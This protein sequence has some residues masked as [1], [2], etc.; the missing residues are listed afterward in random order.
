MSCG[1]FRA[2]R[3][4]DAR[5]AFGMRA[6]AS[7]IPLR[8][9]ETPSR[10]CGTRGAERA[11]R[12]VRSLR[13][14][15]TRTS[16][17]RGCLAFPRSLRRAPTARP[18]PTEATLRK[19]RTNHASTPVRYPHPRTF[20]ATTATQTRTRSSLTLYPSPIVASF[21]IGEATQD[22]EGRINSA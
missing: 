5:V 13:S 10:T 15:A 20:V 9:T 3:R 4:S 16:G 2:S 8:G 17:Y 12:R 14:H 7:R 1:V 21:F 19:R 18:A 22:Q 6:P 11:R